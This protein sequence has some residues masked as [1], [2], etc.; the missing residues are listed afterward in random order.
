MTKQA[1][2]R[3]HDR[4]HRLNDL[5]T[6]LI[7]QESI[8]RMAVSEVCKRL[9][10]ECSIVDPLLMERG[11]REKVFHSGGSAGHGGG[12]GMKKGKRFLCC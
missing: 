6:A 8:K 9:T 7:Q 5:I 3:V 4:L 2:E 10:E 1:D 12:S 11:K